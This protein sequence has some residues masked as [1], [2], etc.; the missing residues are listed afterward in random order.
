MVLAEETVWW[1]KA[2]IR[3]ERSLAGEDSRSTKTGM[4]MQEGG[5]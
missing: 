4:E 3:R 2:G 5:C 1:D